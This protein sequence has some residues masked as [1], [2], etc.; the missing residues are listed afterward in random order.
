MTADPTARVQDADADADDAL[1]RARESLEQTIA[2]LKLTPEEQAALGDELRQLRDLADKL[3]RGTIEI[4]AFGLVSRGKSSVLNALAGREVFEVGATHGTTTRRGVHPW[5]SVTLSDASG[6][7]DAKLVLVDTPGLD[8][9]GGEVR[10]VMARDLARHADLI[11]FVV[12]GDMLRA[13][14]DA[15]AA[16]REAN[17]PILLVFNQIDRY[18]DADREAIHRK[19][20]DERVRD[21]LRPEDI[22]LT[23]ARPDP[24]RVRTRGADGTLVDSWERPAPKVEALKRRIL[25]VLEA[26]GKAIVALNTLL[27][28][29]DLHAE[30]VASTMRL[31]DARADDAIW[32]FAI[33]KGAAVALNPVPVADLA[34]GLAVDV[35]M[36]VALSRLYGIPVTRATAA[37]L[38]REMLVALGAVGAVQVAGR[39]LAGGLKSVL[40]GVTVLSGGLAAPLTAIGY[41][42]IG[43]A[44]GAAAAGVSYVLGQSAKVY[45][46]Q[47]CQWGPRGIKTVVRE[48][49]RRARSDSIVERLRDDLKAKVTR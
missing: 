22:V 8:E 19:I 21:L 39:L 47:G 30:I 28:A 29:G 40:A 36:V 48:I 7:P 27:Y 9:V 5:D 38:V 3:D 1:A 15:L 46:R 37:S 11:L 16:L 2:G 49:L 24:I 4:A 43:L 10:E 23:A 45:L 34:G 14:H 13:E 31:R 12:S 33:A 32:T 35:T 25:E 26:E 17:K 20:A 18:P 6:F 41:G 42:A 44:Q